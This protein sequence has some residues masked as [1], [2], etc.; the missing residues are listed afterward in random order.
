MNWLAHLLLSEPSPEYRLGN[1]LPDMLG[2][3]E[4]KEMP[5][6]VQRGIA[7][8]RFIDRYTDTHD[9]VRQSIRRIPPAHSRV[10]GILV[11]VFYDHILAVNWHLYCEVPLDAFLQEVYRGFTEVEPL[12]PPQIASRLQGLRQADVFGSYRTLEGIEW[13]LRRISQRLSGRYA[14]EEALPVLRERLVEFQGDFS[15][16]FPDLRRK[17]VEFDSAVH[18]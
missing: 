13:A 15:V 12:L 8:H 14:L 4:L 6:T 7:C 1:L 5:P 11:D 17:V 18:F 16:F 9:L 3:T 2:L 10:G